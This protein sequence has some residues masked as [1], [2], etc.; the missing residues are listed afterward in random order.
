MTTSSTT[1]DRS[2]LHLLEE[3]A[4]K[5]LGAGNLGVIL[6]RTGT[7]KTAC[8]VQF[9]LE[10]LLQ[11]R[12]VLHVGLD[13]PV[14]RIRRFYDELFHE[15]S[16]TGAIENPA[17]V[18]VEVERNRHIHSY[19]GHSFSVDKVK[20]GVR[21]LREHMHFIPRVIVI[22][23]LNIETLTEA[24]TQSLLALAAELEAELWFT[25]TV[26]RRDMESAVDGLPGNIEHMRRY[27]S[28]MVQLQGDDRGLHLSLHTGAAW[29]EH[30]RRVDAIL[31][32]ASMQVLKRL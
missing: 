15:L 17:Q 4:P 3:I 18:L 12:R 7:G 26:H 9:T 16:K 32:S 28:V 6:G 30:G 20:E 14:Q 22:D 27:I 29:T 10:H 21:F 13:E 19:L 23:G 2:P 1:R 11:G 31:D 25:T 8:L 5:G 24:E